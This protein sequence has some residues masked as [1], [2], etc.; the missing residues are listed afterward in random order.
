MNNNR[1]VRERTIHFRV[2]MP[3]TFEELQRAVEGEL[4][5]DVM[6]RTQVD[7]P[8][9]GQAPIRRERELVAGSN[10]REL[11]DQHRPGDQVEL[12]GRLLPNEG[13]TRYERLVFEVP[14][15]R[16]EEIHVEGRTGPSTLA[17]PGYDGPAQVPDRAGRW[18][19]AQQLLEEA[20]GGAIVG[21]GPDQMWTPTPTCISRMMPTLPALFGPRA[22][23]EAGNAVPR[24]IHTSHPSSQHMPQPHSVTVRIFG[25]MLEQRFGINNAG[26]AQELGDGM[27]RSV[28]TELIQTTRDSKQAEAV[29]DRLL[30]GGTSEFGGG[31]II[32]PDLRAYQRARQ[33]YFLGDATCL[34][35]YVD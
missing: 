24:V 4:S 8:G 13:A 16:G 30:H 22:N 31:S 25:E 19:R 34:W 7:Q 26:G 14:S 29:R 6:S 32:E 3:A 15:I 23:A 18:R 9:G 28:I 12:D 10:L 5:R 1:P 21:S 33:A 17:P 27:I 2:R 11:Y 35:R 20:L